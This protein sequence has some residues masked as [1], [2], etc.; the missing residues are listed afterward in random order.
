M[1]GSTTQRTLYSLFIGYQEP[2]HQIS[3]ELFFFYSTFST[4]R[5][6]YF[7]I[8]IPNLLHLFTRTFSY[9]LFPGSCH[10]SLLFPHLIHLEGHSYFISNILSVNPISLNIPTHPSQHA[11]FHYLHLLNMEFFIG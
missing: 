5:V 3:F 9:F 6:L 4:F 11:H 10:L 1:N 8:T 2:V 7:V